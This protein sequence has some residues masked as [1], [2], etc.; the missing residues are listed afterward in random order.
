MATIGS[1]SPPIGQ[2]GENTGFSEGI[3]KSSGTDSKA[4]K[5]LF[6]KLLVAQLKYQDPTKPTD[7][8]EM[9]SQTAQF[10]MVEKM[11][12]LVDAYTNE[13]QATELTSATAMLGST[14]TYTSGDSTKTGVVSGVSITNGTPTLMVGSQEVALTA[15]TKVQKTPATTPAPSTP[16]A[17][18]SGTTPPAAGGTTPPATPPATGGGTTPPTTASMA[19]QAVGSMYTG[20]AAPAPAWADG[21]GESSSY[22]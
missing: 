10:T 18:G 1:I 12:Q 2:V 13:M 19:A 14:I 11:D 7:T 17:T 4:D 3:G 8:S 15:V 16:P 21:D 22:A 9:L 6:L 5:D 20:G